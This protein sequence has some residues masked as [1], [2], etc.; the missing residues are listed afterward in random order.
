MKLAAICMGTVLV[1]GMA[2]S[3]VAAQASPPD[4]DQIGDLVRQLDDGRFAV[5]DRADRELRRLG[6]DVLPFLDKEIKATK[7]EEVRQR[8]TK[9]TD[10]L[11]RDQR[12]A[13]LA[14]AREQRIAALVAGLGALRYRDRENATAELLLFGKEVV[15]ILQKERAR[16]PDIETQRRLESIIRKLSP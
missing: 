3:L 1:V 12:M 6:K 13:A 16:A 5:R 10:Y 15:P 7:S 9:I 4:P 11:T 8:L 14:K 2:A